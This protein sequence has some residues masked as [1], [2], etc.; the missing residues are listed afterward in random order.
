MPY[1]LSGVKFRD[2]RLVA[3]M[4]THRVSHLLTFNSVGFKRFP[5]TA[6]DLKEHLTLM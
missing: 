6:I 1:L 5:I 3:V 2:A 4:M